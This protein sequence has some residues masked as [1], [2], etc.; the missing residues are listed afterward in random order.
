MGTN[1]YLKTPMQCSATEQIIAW[2]AKQAAQSSDDAAAQTLAIHDAI[3]DGRAVKRPCPCCAQAD[4]EWLHIGKSSGG[5]CFSLRVY[6]ALHGDMTAH[7]LGI[8]PIEN[9]DDWIPLFE[10]YGVIN[11]YG[12]EIDTDVMLRKRRAWATD[13]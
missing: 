2:L 4:R 13:R 9:L 10:R 11:E 3:I 6:P 5:W 12:E 7:N 8:D 1:F